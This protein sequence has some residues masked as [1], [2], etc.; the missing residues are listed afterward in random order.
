MCLS[1]VVGTISSILF[2]F[3]VF[4]SSFIT[5]YLMSA[6]DDNDSRFSTF[7]YSSYWIN[8]FDVAQDLVRAALRIMKDEQGILGDLTMAPSSPRRIIIGPEPAPMQ[9]G[10]IRAFIR[11]VFLGLPVVGA[12]SLV[13]FLMS[14]PMLGPVQWLARYRGSR[15]RENSRD[16]AALVLVILLIVG[17]LRYNHFTI[18]L[19]LSF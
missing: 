6:F 12:G 8:P 13:Q 5:T 14:M 11:R 1:V 19:M 10:Y 17:A 15:R 3:I 9:R 2:T 16:M 7:I 4:L 18:H